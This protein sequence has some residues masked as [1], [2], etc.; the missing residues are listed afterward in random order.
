MTREKECNSKKICVIV[1]TDTKR[2][3]DETKYYLSQ[4]E[5]PEGFEIELYMI[6][7]LEVSN[8]AR[9]FNDV[10]DSSDAK[11]KVYIRGGVLPLNRNIYREF[12]RIFADASVG[13]IGMIGSSRFPVE[14][15]VK[16][17]A[18]IGSVYLHQY[19][20]NEAV[21]FNPNNPDHE[22]YYAEAIDD[23]LMATQYDLPWKDD[24]FRGNSLIFLSQCQEFSNAFYKIVVPYQ[25]NPWVLYDARYPDE[26]Y[27]EE[28]KE[29]FS[30]YYQNPSWK[31]IRPLL[32]SFDDN[33]GPLVSIV[34]T[35]YNHEKYVAEAIE[36][37]YRQ[38]YG[39]IELIVTDDGSTDD[40]AKVIKEKLSELCFKN[41][42]TILE[43][44]NTCFGCIEKAFKLAKGKYVAAFGGD[45]LMKPDKI[46]TQ[47][48]FLEEYEGRYD[49]CFTWVEVDAGS[50]GN[51]PDIIERTQRLTKTFNRKNFRDN[52]WLNHFL[53]NGNCLNAPSFMMRRDVFMELKGFD[54]S[55]IQLQDM[56]LWMRFLMDHRLYVI[57][58]ILT[59]YRLVPN[60]LSN[61]G[62]LDG[63]IRT[64]VEIENLY[65]EIL[66][67]MPDEVFDRVF[68]DP[69]ISHHST[70][71]ILCRKTKLY[72][73]LLSEKIAG[74][75]LIKLFY[76]YRKIDGYLELL[77]SRYGISRAWI[78]KFIKEGT[79]WTQVLASPKN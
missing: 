31:R 45:D 69:I 13:M 19:Y 63:Y 6:D 72:M 26:K 60:S 7:L 57:P 11:Y 59:V 10:I 3:G 52:G 77:G 15:R 51:N 74:N 54:Y 37:V 34:L 48:A 21:T 49:A 5:V 67:N 43:A 64:H 38:S 66:V 17:E 9:A 29:I 23:F 76:R 20:A 27:L 71:D 28:D 56:D 79:I 61:G 1:Y 53:L 14:Y 40:S 36:S 39:N 47:V 4:L 50:Y 58:E 33:Q 46:K 22:D 70:L 35:C 16:S 12:L 8:V 41:V 62:G 32:N 42:T 24:I 30:D 25:E 68:P 75:I 73:D 55:Y 18:D 65:Y 2:A 78:H 44:E